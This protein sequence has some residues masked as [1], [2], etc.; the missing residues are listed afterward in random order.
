MRSQDPL[1]GFPH[2]QLQRVLR[3]AGVYRMGMVVFLKERLCEVVIYDEV[4]IFAD[5]AVR[6]HLLSR[7]CSALCTHT[8]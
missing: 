5:A 7:F 8:V 3:D 2:S 6:A 1:S 4:G